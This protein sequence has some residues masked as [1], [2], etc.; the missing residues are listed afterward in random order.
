MKR[1]EVLAATGGWELIVESEDLRLTDGIKKIYGVEADRELSLEEVMEFYE[2]ESQEQISKILD[3]AIESGYAETDELHLQTANGDHRIVK[4]NA[5]LVETDTDQT[6]LR[7]VIH[8]ITDRHEQQQE[9]QLLQ[10]AIDDADVSITLADPSQSDEP[11]VYVNTAF[12]EMTGYPPKETLGR[13]CRFLQGE[14]TDPQKAATL[15]EAINNEESVSVEL[16]NYRKDGTEFWSRV[17]VTPIYDDNGQLVRYLGTQE[18]VTTRKEREREL[19]AE[20]RFIRQAI[21]GLDDLFYVI[22]TD[23]RLRRWNNTC[24]EVTGYDDSELADMQVNRVFPEKDRQTVENAVETAL[25]EGKVTFEAPLQTADGTNIPYEFTGARLIDEDGSITGIVGIGRDIT[26]RKERERE[27]DQTRDLMAN[28]EQLADVGAWKYDPNTEELTNT[29][30]ARAI[31]NIER[32]SEMSLDEAFELF[33][34]DDRARLRTRFRECLE[35][36]KPYEIDV[37]LSLPNGEQHWVTARGQRVQTTQEEPAVRGSI[38]I[39][40]SK[41][42]VSNS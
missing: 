10:Q 37:R 23:G 13:N 40:L 5:E 38:Q 12:E 15:R 26:S 25:S 36:G 6:I 14:D 3:T 20:R 33:H 27:L 19:K 28:M 16:R 32:E 24:N 18:D 17:T 1:T 41:S 35:T 34:A 21:D 11:L 39:L 42:I 2:P 22:D 7:G 9:L 4:G 31:Q 30:G 29:P 8:D